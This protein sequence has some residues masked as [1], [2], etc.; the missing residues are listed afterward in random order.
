MVGGHAG[1]L[2]ARFATEMSRGH[3]PRNTN[4]AYIA[5]FIRESKKKNITKA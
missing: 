1:L 4:L 3:M 2:S 5:T